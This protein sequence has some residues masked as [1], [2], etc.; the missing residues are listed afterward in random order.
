MD[1]SKPPS[2]MLNTD[3]KPSLGARLGS[4]FGKK[5]GT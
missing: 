3:V 5:S 4:W 1:S 2:E